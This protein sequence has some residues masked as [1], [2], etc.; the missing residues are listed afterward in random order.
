MYRLL[1]FV[2]NTKIEFSEEIFDIVGKPSFSFNEYAIS[3]I[4]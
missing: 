3:S 2:E 4:L 1:S